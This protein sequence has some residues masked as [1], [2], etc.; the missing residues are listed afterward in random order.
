[1]RFMHD[2]SYD[3]TRMLQKIYQKSQ[4]HRVRQRAQCILLSH[5]G[6]TTNELA[7]LFQVNRITI[8]NWFNA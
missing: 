8:Y 4:Y 6:Y 2:V 7:H 5:Q 3:T 1:M